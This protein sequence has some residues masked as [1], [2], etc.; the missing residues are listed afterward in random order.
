VT[1]AIESA[2]AATTASTNS[3]AA[4]DARLDIRV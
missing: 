2:S 3:F 1:A 4:G